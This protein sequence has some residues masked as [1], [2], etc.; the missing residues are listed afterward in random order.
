MLDTDLQALGMSPKEVAVYKAVLEVGKVTPARIST[1]TGI[2][3]TTVYAVGNDLVAQGYLQVDETRATT[4]FFPTPPKD[5]KKVAKRERQALIQKELILDELARSISE[6]P[7]SKTYSVPTIKFIEHETKIEEYLYE[8]T[9]VWLASGGVR[10]MW[11]GF[12]D[13]TFTAH[14]PYQKW[15]DWCWSQ[16]ESK[17]AE[18]NMISNETQSELETTARHPRRHVKYL[19]SDINF[20]STHWILGEYSV[21]VVTRQKPHYLVEMHD[22]VYAGNMHALYQRMWEEIK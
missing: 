13:G 14:Q 12:L 15:I 22:A 11:H 7:Q 17:D 16:P 9:K 5:L 4:Y 2:N 8:R 21:M 6:L 3:R 10:P 19:K 20:T 18:L 1:M